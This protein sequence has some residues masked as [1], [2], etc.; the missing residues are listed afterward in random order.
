MEEKSRD[1]SRS[2][3]WSSCEDAP[4]LLKLQISVALLG[5]ER[6]TRLWQPTHRWRR[7]KSSP[8]GATKVPAAP[9]NILKAE[10]DNLRAS[11]L[12]I[13]R[14]P[15]NGEVRKITSFKLIPLNSPPIVSIDP[16]Y[17]YFSMDERAALRYQR[18]LREGKLAS[19][20]DG[21]VPVYLQLQDETGFHH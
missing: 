14:K 10:F 6:I 4:S 8:N 2:A 21:K 16:I 17:A 12:Q 18:L 20:Q 11:Q 7:H 3:N 15:K 9:I 19:S 5:S 13:P 1:I